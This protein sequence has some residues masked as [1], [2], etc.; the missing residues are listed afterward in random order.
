MSLFYE[1]W[2]LAF[3]RLND[4]RCRKWPR[5]A[6]ARLPKVHI[7]KPGLLYASSPLPYVSRRFQQHLNANRRSVAPPVA[8]LNSTLCFYGRNSRPHSHFRPFRH[9]SRNF[10][11]QREFSHRPLL[12]HFARAPA[13]ARA[14]APS[15]ACSPCMITA[16]ASCTCIA[17]EL[18]IYSYVCCYVTGCLPV[19]LSTCVFILVLS[20]SGTQ[21]QAH[22]ST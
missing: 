7:F 14:R 1:N 4:R 3:A 21:Q 15:R 10:T 9:F 11:V 6:R 13:L 18:R 17:L 22:P 5:S 20:S 12:A 8:Q 19:H 2:R 16:A